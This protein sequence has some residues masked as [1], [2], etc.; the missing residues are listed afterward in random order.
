MESE[1]HVEFSNVKPGGTKRALG[2][3]RIIQ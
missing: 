2:F 1:D 3:K